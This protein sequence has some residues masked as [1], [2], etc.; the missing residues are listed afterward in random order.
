VLDC[1]EAGNGRREKFLKRKEH[2]F[3]TGK[4]GPSLRQK[5]GGTLVEAGNR[6]KEERKG[7]GRKEHSLEC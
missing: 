2:F 3:D 7:Q 5:K 1:L 6:R 4:K